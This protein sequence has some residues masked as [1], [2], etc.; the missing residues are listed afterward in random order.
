MGKEATLQV[1]MEPGLKA[2]AEELYLIDETGAAIPKGAKG[3]GRMTG[4]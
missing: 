2:G 1:R 4:R 3:G